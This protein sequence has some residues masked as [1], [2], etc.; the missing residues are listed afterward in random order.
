MCEEI[1]PFTSWSTGVGHELEGMVEGQPMKEM[2]MDLHN[3]AIG[4]AAGESGTEIDLN[5][6]QTS[7]DPNTKY[8]PVPCK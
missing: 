7:P 3:N 1:G 2:Q 4:R 6:L 8:I 5:E